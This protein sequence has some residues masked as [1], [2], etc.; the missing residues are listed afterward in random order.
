MQLDTMYPTSNISVALSSSNLS[1]AQVEMILELGVEE[2][3]FALDKQ[4]KECYTEEYKIYQQKIIKL[5]SKLTPYVNV[6]ILWDKEGLL[7]YKDAPTDQG[8]EVFEHLMRKRIE[9]KTKN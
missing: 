8:K 6:T 4:Y 1:N 9:I 3:I 2:V 5:A 7:G